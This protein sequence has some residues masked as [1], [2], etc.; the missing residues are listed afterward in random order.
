MPRGDAD[1]PS[2]TR[3]FR[4]FRVGRWAVE[5]TL[6]EI[7][8]D[9]ARQRLEPKAMA[10]L[11]LLARRAPGVVSR[12]EIFDEVWEGRA[13]VD[14][15]LT[16]AVSLLR[17]AFG[18]DS[19]NPTFI[20]TIPTRGYRLIAPLQWQDAEESPAPST[21]L[22]TRQLRRALS[23]AAIVVASL[24][25][26]GWAIHASMEHRHRAARA[27]GR[28]GIAVLPFTAVSATNVDTAM[29]TG[30][31][32]ELTHQ[33]ASVAGLKVVSRTSAARFNASEKSAAEIADALD[34]DYLLDGSVLAFDATVRIHARLI[35][36]ASDE[37]LLSRRY[38]EPIED[39]IALQH[40]VAQDVVEETRILVT[41][42][43]RLRL[44]TSTRVDPVA[45]RMYLRALSELNRRANVQHAVDLLERVVERDPSLPMAWAALAEAHLLAVQYLPIGAG[46]DAAERAIDR[47]LDL[48]PDNAQAHAALGLLRTSR[49]QNWHQAEAAYRRAIE[50]EP[51]SVTAQQWY[52]EM[53][54][55]SFQAERSV[56]QIR[57]ALELDPFSPLVHAAAGQR[58]HAA[59]QYALAEAHLVEV[60]RLG[61]RFTWHLIELS[62]VQ[63]RLGDEQR[64]I[65]TRRHQLERA[66]IAA[67]D[68][69]DLDARILTDGVHGY[70]TWYLEHLERTD[71]PFG[72]RRAEAL[73]ALGRHDEALPWIAAAVE[74]QTMWFL[75][76]QRSPAF[77]RLRT[78][79]RFVEIAGDLPLWHPPP[80][81]S[82]RTS[83]KDSSRR[84]Q[85]AVSRGVLD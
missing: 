48:D 35:R 27:L 14:E 31:T 64:A 55:L 66:G 6:L 21:T 75:H 78:D 70:W 2:E 24:L 7:R 68:L 8:N 11:Q 44:N 72:M 34:V 84:R 19:K 29:A 43:E 56:R 9:D 57:I 82:T 61:P 20:E 50:L 80:N 32:D 41:A 63:S 1:I 46:H 71:D 52:S 69:A 81:P 60:D 85:D 33:L 23:S 47:A 51:S 45:Y 40:R 18:D 10:L 59:G 76:R 5:P 53:L 3:T 37:H 38:E 79:P 73:A 36:A 17:Q 74:N 30:L 22:Y 26:I 67:D 25:A 83:H 16:R 77:D 65:A 49:D 54:S 12:D 13:V 28:P 62:M 15:T 42:D 58:L 39:V 4:P